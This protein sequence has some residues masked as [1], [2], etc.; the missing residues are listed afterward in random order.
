[1]GK[2]RAP[3]LRALFRSWVRRHPNI[4]TPRIVRV[5]QK[6]FRIIEISAGTDFKE[7]PIYG[8]SEIIYDPK[9]H[10]FNAGKSNRSTVFQ[11]SNAK[12]EA[13]D[14]ADTL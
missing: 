1:M 8:V 5:V 13:M 7:N 2:K 11:G 14:Y 3:P 10:T 6:D 9:E 12:K 4:M